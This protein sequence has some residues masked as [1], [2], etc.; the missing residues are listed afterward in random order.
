[1]GA[2]LCSGGVR[3][4]P[5]DFSRGRFGDLWTASIGLDVGGAP[6]SKCQDVFRIAAVERTHL[7][8]GAGEALEQAVALGVRDDGAQWLPPTVEIAREDEMHRPWGYTHLPR[9]TLSLRSFHRPFAGSP[10]RPPPGP[11]RGHLTRSLG[12]GSPP[13]QR[14][15]P[16][17]GGP[18]VL[19]SRNSHVKRIDAASAPSSI[20]ATA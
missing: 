6:L 19:P 8:I 12:I 3:A 13:P 1:M 11:A 9:W 10:R 17:G 20:A 16:T 2:L 14:P 4:R 15:K 18:L 7:V 5:C